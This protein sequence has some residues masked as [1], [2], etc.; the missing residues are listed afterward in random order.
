MN[1]SD[2]IPTKFQY[3]KRHH[4]QRSK[5]RYRLEEDVQR[6]NTTSQVLLSRKHK[7]MTKMSK[8]IAECTKMPRDIQKTCG[9]SSTREIWTGN[10]DL[11]YISLLIIFEFTGLDEF[12]YR[13]KA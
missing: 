6:S 7:S 3:M 13:R 12:A 8:A 11:G 5:K 1:K 10:R 9:I 4:K 2:Y